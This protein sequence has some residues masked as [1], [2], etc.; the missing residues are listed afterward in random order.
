VCD[1]GN[2]IAVRFNSMA[3]ARAS[4]YSASN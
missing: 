4:V 3:E 2:S 1:A